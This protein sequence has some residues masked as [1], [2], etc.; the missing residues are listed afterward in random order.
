MSR[1]FRF[2]T[3]RSLQDSARRLKAFA[4]RGHYYSRE[5]RFE[6]HFRLDPVIFSQ[7]GPGEAAFRIPLMGSPRWSRGLPV[8]LYFWLTGILRA[9]ENETDVVFELGLGRPPSRADWIFFLFAWG[10]ITLALF[11]GVVLALAA[12]PPEGQLYGAILLLAGLAHSWLLRQ[13]YQRVMEEVPPLVY[14]ALA[15]TGDPAS[16]DSSEPAPPDW[17]SSLSGSG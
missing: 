5:G 11:G 7:A 8:F 9:R 17:I 6:T 2:S 10:V 3:G 4:A 1:K 16:P 15:G 12:P 14:Q 13:I